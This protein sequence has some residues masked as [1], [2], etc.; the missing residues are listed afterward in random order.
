MGQGPLRTSFAGGGV[1]LDPHVRE[2]DVAVDDREVAGVRGLGEGLVPLVIRV[3]AGPV[4]ARLDLAFQFFIQHDAVDAPAAD[5][6]EAAG[7][8]RGRHRTL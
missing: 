3:E 7:F 8:G 5:G 1:V 6:S 2:L 4:R